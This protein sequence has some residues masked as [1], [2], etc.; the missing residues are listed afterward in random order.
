MRSISGPLSFFFVFF[1][2][3][4]FSEFFLVPCFFSI[5]K[6]VAARRR[7]RLG[8]LSMYIAYVCTRY[9]PATQRQVG[10]AGRARAIG[11]EK[12]GPDRGTIVRGVTV[13][14]CWH[15]VA[16]CRFVDV[17][18]V[19][20]VV[21]VNSDV[22]IV[23][24]AVV[25]VHVVDVVPV[26]VIVIAVVVRLLIFVFTWRDIFLLT[27]RV[28]FFLSVF[29]SFFLFDFLL[30]GGTLPFVTFY[31]FRLN[32][33]DPSIVADRP[34]ALLAF[35]ERKKDRAQSKRSTSAVFLFYLGGRW[36]FLGHPVKERYIVKCR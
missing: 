16:C 6:D 7:I 2:R 10:T 25:V 35:R 9:L 17:V 24:V 33:F 12:Y 32:R 22:V 36:E 8:V 28:F 21:S 13:R 5:T 18:V 1:F 26:A 34:C 4:L 3:G 27:K 20:D 30:G 29:V 14:T 23:D 15:V 31:E 11:R 19:L